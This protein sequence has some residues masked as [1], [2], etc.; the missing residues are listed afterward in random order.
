MRIGTAAFFFNHTSTW[1]QKGFAAEKGESFAQTGGFLHFHYI[2]RDSSMFRKV[3][4]DSG[5]HTFVK[6]QLSESVKACKSCHGSM[7]QRDLRGFQTVLYSC[8][9]MPA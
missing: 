9:Y 3:L 1:A 6:H 8:N 7:L 2:Y 5:I 4:L